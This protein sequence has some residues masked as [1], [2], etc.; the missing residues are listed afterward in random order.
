[1]NCYIIGNTGNNWPNLFLK[2]SNKCL[3]IIG[4]EGE[5]FLCEDHIGQLEVPIEITRNC[6][7]RRV[8]LL[9]L[10]LM[11]CC[12]EREWREKRVKKYL[13]SIILA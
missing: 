12:S 4:G 7:Q 3:A 9:I 2:F 6:K 13:I 8:K 10:V 11:D 5:K 1:M